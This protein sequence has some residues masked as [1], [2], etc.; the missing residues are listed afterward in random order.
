ME[1]FFSNILVAIQSLHWTEVGAVI[2][3]LIYIF[4][5]VKENVWGWFWGI[6]SCGLWAWATYALYNLYVDAILNIFYVIMGFAG[7]YQ[8]KFGSKNK[9][10]IP[11][12][13][14]TVNQHVIVMI[15][16]LLLT[17]VIGFIFEKFTEADKTY[18]DSLTTSFAIFATFMTIQKKIENWLYWIVVDLLYIYIYWI[19]GAFLFMLLYVVYCVIAVKGYFSWK[20]D[21]EG[22][23]FKKND[24]ILDDIFI[25]SNREKKS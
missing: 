5:V 25:P 10:E 1:D 9:G 14:M 19:T 6:L 16:G 4:L 13:Q 22:T 2:F 21:F 12:T 11:I 8:W 20:K 3:G 7:I 15:A 17:F 18:L 23:H 24:K